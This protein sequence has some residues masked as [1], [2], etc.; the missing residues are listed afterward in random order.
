MTKLKASDY[1][2]K[3]RIRVKNHCGSK[4]KEAFWMI[5]QMD[6]FLN[7]SQKRAKMIMLMITSLL[8]LNPESLSKI[9]LV[10]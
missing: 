6:F 8:I 9:N 5:L 10:A 7:K 4:V 1:F 2:M 3:V